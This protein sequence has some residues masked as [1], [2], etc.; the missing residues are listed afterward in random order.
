MQEERWR[1]I[2]DCTDSTWKMFR[3]WQ[4]FLCA[5]VEFGNLNSTVH[6]KAH[7]VRILPWCGGNSG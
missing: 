3:Q 4:D 1:E 5:E 7:A 6:T 2:L